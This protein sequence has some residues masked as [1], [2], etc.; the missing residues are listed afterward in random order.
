MI[1]EF[2]KRARAVEPN[3]RLVL[4]SKSKVQDVRLE[5]GDIISIP[6]RQESVMVNGEVMVSQA[7]L[8]GQDLDIAHYLNRSGGLT[9]QANTDAYLLVKQSGEVLKGKSF[10][11]A[12]GDEIIVLPKVPV[13]N[14]QTASTIS[15]ILYKIAIAASVAIRL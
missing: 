3:G 2:I 1:S 7:V 15:D 5:M 11:I 9:D 8:W 6:R 13:K 4:A 14:L 12:A 10:E